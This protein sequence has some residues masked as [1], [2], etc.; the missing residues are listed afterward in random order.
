MESTYNPEVIAQQAYTT[1]LKAVESPGAQKKLAQALGVSEATMSRLK[2][3]AEQ[4]FRAAAHTKHTLL[5]VVEDQSQRLSPEVIRS[6][7][8][9]ARHNL[10]EMAE[11]INRE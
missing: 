3:Q 4:V 10:G 8:V 1:F 11:Q 2:A 9:I 6:L 7:V 5:P